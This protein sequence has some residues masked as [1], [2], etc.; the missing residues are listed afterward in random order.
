M[1][2]GALIC[3]QAGSKCVLQLNISYVVRQQNSYD[4][5]AFCRM[6]CH[7]TGIHTTQF[8]CK[9]ILTQLFDFIVNL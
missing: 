9:S 7:I 4:L 1:Q 5:A 3:G 2:S 8:C 6:M